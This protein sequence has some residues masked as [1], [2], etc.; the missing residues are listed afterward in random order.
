M[1]AKL[2]SLP[3]IDDFR[4]AYILAQYPHENGYRAATY[5]EFYNWINLRLELSGVEMAPVQGGVSE[6]TATL[7]PPGPVGQQRKMDGSPGWYSVNGVP[8]EAEAGKVWKFFWNGSAW[9]LVDMGELPVPDVSGFTEKGGYEGTAQDLDDRI[10]EVDGSATFA[11]NMAINSQSTANEAL[12]TVDQA[13]ANTLAAVEN[14][15]WKTP[16]IGN[17]SIT[18]GKLSQEVRD[19]INFV[20][21]GTINNAPDGEDLTADESVLKLK[22]GAEGFSRVRVKSSFSALKAEIESKSAFGYILIKD[23]LDFQNGGN[24]GSIT[25]PEGTTVRFVGSGMIKNAVLNANGVKIEAN[26][27]RIF[28]NVELFYYGADGKIFQHNIDMTAVTIPNDYPKSV[29]NKK[30]KQII[31]SGSIIN[32]IDV[33]PMNDTLDNLTKPEQSGSNWVWKLN[34]VIE[35]R[36]TTGAG[37]I[38]LPI[39]GQYQ[40]FNA[41]TNEVLVQGQYYDPETVKVA[42]LRDYSYTARARFVCDKIYPEWFGAVA[43]G[44]T[45]NT[46]AFNQCL[47][48]AAVQTSGAAIELAGSSRIYNVSGGL[49]ARDNVTIYGNKSWIRLTPNATNHMF[50]YDTIKRMVGFQLKNIIL[51]GNK[52]NQNIPLNGIFFDWVFDQPYYS[53]YNWDDAVLEDVKFINF[54]QDGMYSSTP[55]DVNLISCKFMYNDRDGYSWDSEHFKAYECTAWGNGRDGAKAS[56]NHW[57]IIGGAYAHNGRHNINCDGAFEFQIVAPSAIDCPQNNINL[58]NCYRFTINGARILQGGKGVYASST[59]RDGVVSNCLI[60]GNTVDV[61][62]TGK[63]IRFSS[64]YNV[65]DSGSD[66]IF[67]PRADFA[68][69]SIANGKGIYEMFGSSPFNGTR[70]AILASGVVGLPA[71]LSAPVQLTVSGSTLITGGVPVRQRM[72]VTLHDSSGDSI[73]ATRS[74]VYEMSSQTDITD[75]GWKIT[76]QQSTFN[77]INWS[78]PL[79]TIPRRAMSIDFTVGANAGNPNPSQSLLGTS[80]CISIPGGYRLT[81]RAVNNGNLYIREYVYVTE[82]NSYTTDTGWIKLMKEGEDTQ[83]NLSSIDWSAPLSTLGERAQKLSYYSVNN[84]TNPATGVSLSGDM[85]VF[86][87]TNGYRI[88]VKGVYSGIFCIREMVYNNSTQTYINDTGWINLNE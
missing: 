48:A 55:G 17:E 85:S 61:D 29:F 64:N 1:D 46:I 35:I 2:N 57:R 84:A 67:V 66:D 87:V 21:G 34:G 69:Y 80:Q 32:P 26:R 30:T 75:S 10:N 51:N 52:T 65:A 59:A 58:T 28:D 44:T 16:N 18:P 8:I 23:I 22:D 38:L 40:F 71:G 63:N 74:L 5:E 24:R 11:K 14:K 88:A 45:D 53:G 27:K 62:S 60:F 31:P 25:I 81:I 50:I 78:A 3:K 79:S 4:M 72:F 12:N 86:P 77:S 19:M 47:L 42:K 7:I 70:K 33:K 68:N 37:N 15:I 13:M 54:T 56:G 6:E 76:G 82:S 43:D 9:A 39:S 36:F 41:S 83:V 20:G 49:I 73:F